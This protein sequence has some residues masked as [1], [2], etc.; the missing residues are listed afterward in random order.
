MKPFSHY[1]KSVTTT[2]NCGNAVVTDS[3]I[4]NSPPNGALDNVVTTLPP[5]PLEKH[6][7]QSNHDSSDTIISETNIG[8]VS[9]KEVTEKGNAAKGSNTEPFENQVS[10]TTTDEP[11]LVL[12]STADLIQI[13]E[14]YFPEDVP[15]NI[16]YAVAGKIKELDTAR[17]TAV[18]LRL[19]RWLGEFHNLDW[20][21]CQYELLTQAWD[22]QPRQDFLLAKKMFAGIGSRVVINGEVLRNER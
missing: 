10:V 14:N 21:C 7:L 16:C 17:Q 2:K 15:H 8:D 9:V 12:K 11:A 6:Y 1:F 4:R 20:V 5:L 22:S 19:A 13:M 3:E 18:W